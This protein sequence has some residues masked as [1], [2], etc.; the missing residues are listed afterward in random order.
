MTTALANFVYHVLY[1]LNMKEKVVGTYS[2][3]SKTFDSVYHSLLLS[4]LKCY[5]VGGLPVKLIALYLKN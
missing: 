1:L 2:L 5:G 4:N 3:L